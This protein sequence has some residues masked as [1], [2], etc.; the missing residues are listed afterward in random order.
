MPPSSPN[1]NNKQPA[2]AE[3]HRR[4]RREAIAAGIDPEEVDW[5]LQALYGFDKLSL[6]LGT[7]SSQGVSLSRLEAL[8]QERIQNRRPVQ[9][10]AERVP[11]RHFC[12][13][14]TPAVL[15][16]RPETE[17]IIELAIAAVAKT[18]ELGAG[19]WVDLG[20]GSGAIALGL[21]AAFPRARV[22]AIDTSAEALAI[23]G[24]NARLN[25]LE[26][27]IEFRLG[28]WFEP[29]AGLEGAIAGGVS[30]P[31]YIPSELVPQLQP[32]VSAHEPHLALDG[33]SDGLDCLREL[34]RCAPV[35]LR[36]GG[37]LALE[38]MAGQGDRVSQLLADRGSYRDIQIAED[39]AGRDRFA[40]ARRV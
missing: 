9:Y 28:S 29:L 20:T 5:L 6:R 11:W 15:I 3:W 24:E 14:V 34:V 4:A 27:S 1:P 33:G 35:Y 40:T 21:A 10:L 38:M 31:P 16:P 7:Y 19:I 13:R 32:E 37:I 25:G 17:Q 18:P 26:A 39:W 2:L 12:L 22:L 36:A 30:N 23:A 8:W